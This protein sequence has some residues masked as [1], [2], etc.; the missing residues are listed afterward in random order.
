[1]NVKGLL[2]ALLLIRITAANAATIFGHRKTPAVAGAFL[3]A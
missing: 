3:L 2:S 1:M